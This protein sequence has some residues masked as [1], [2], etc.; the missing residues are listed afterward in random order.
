MKIH[1]W[2]SRKSLSTVGDGKTGKNKIYTYSNMNKKN[3]EKYT[4]EELIEMLL[5]KQKPKQKL[6]KQNRMKNI[7]REMLLSDLPNII[8]SKILDKK[9]SQL[10]N[11]KKVKLNIRKMDHALRNYNRSYEVSV[12]ANKNPLIQLDRTRNGIYERML[13]TLQS[14]KG[15]NYWK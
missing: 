14:I 8:K 2:M 1:T 13:K 11:P 3:L 12:I 7:I 10:I 9:Y 4:K 5:E 15:S 6:I